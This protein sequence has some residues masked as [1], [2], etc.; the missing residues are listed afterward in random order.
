MKNPHG[1]EPTRYMN[2]EESEYA[3]D[4]FPYNGPTFRDSYTCN[5]DIRIEDFYNSENHCSIL[6]DGKGGY[7]CHPE[8]KSSLFVNTAGPD[9]ENKCSVLDYE[10]FG[11]D[12]DIRD[13]INKLCKYPDIIWEC[14]KTKDISEESLKQVD[15]DLDLLN[16][17]DV[18]HCDNTT[19]R[20]KISRYYLKKPS[21][22]LP[23]T[24][25]VN[26]QYDSYLRE[27]AGDYKWKLIYRASEHGYTAKS[28]H[29]CCDDKGPTLVVIKSSGGWIFGGYT[30]Q[31]WKV[32]HSNQWEGIYNGIL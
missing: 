14:I 9:E 25:I 27:W 6:N 18:I 28:F 3:I 31:S 17:L 22:L 4:C 21:E 1:V 5:H 19:I 2:R 10:V 12:F 11:I 29:E 23:N 15:D 20:V 26:Q 30:T 13:N 24:Y 32:F 16:D 8:Y 7:Y